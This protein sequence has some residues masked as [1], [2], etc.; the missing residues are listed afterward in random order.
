MSLKQLLKQ[1]VPCNSEERKQ[2]NERERIIMNTHKQSTWRKREEG[3]GRDK[4]TRRK[5]SENQNDSVCTLYFR[6]EVE[7]II[8]Y[9]I[10][11]KY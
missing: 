9:S 8:W 7:T 3:R 10:A 4:K 2:I 6:Y 5:K 1:I 11:V